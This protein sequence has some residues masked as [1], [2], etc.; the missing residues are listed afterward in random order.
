MS[1]VLSTISMT[2]DAVANIL[3]Q[4]AEKD[5]GATISYDDDRDEYTECHSP[6]TIHTYHSHSS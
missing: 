4:S 2:P 6:M 3:S 1:L 5:N